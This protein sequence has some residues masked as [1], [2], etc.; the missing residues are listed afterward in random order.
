MDRKCL[1]EGIKG[2][3]NELT[4][5]TM[6]ETYLY[7][8]EGEETREM[9][10]SLGHGRQSHNKTRNDQTEDDFEA[11]WSLSFRGVDYTCIV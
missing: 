5:T 7:T 10:K 1:D 6:E 11:L 4:E 3:Q 2:K 8:Q 9:L